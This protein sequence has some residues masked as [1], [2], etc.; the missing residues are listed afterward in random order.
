MAI[1]VD[2]NFN[3]NRRFYTCQTH[4]SPREVQVIAWTINTDYTEA[5]RV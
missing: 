4:F 3:A 1:L 2:P 5:T